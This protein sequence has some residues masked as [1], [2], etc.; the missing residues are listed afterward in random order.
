MKDFFDSLRQQIAERMSNP[1]LGSF[2]IAWLVWNHLYLIILFSDLPVEY[3]FTLARSHFYP[4]FSDGVWRF[5]TLPALSSLAY[6]LI[7]PPVSIPL[8]A[9]WD[10]LQRTINRF[11]N[12]AQGNE[13][14]TVDISRKIISDAGVARKK[15]EEQIASLERELDALKNP[16]VGV[17]TEDN[18]M[19]DLK[20]QNSSLRDEVRKMRQDLSPQNPLGR[21]GEETRKGIGALLIALAKEGDGAEP[22]EGEVLK[23]LGTDQIRA[24]HLID[25]ALEAQIIARHG[26]ARGNIRLSLNERGRDYLINH[27]LWQPK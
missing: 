13:L 8:L 20:L 15:Y 21:Y 23:S 2:I 4:T 18:T 10:F 26:D 5:V 1:I 19:V 22:I 12:R 11:R 7:Y 17:V 14:L 27:K 6:I 9:Y 3:R 25:K 16:G 24:R